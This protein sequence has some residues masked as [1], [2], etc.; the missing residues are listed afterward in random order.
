MSGQFFFASGED[1]A[2]SKFADLPA[3]YRY[4]APPPPSSISSTSTLDSAREAGGFTPL[5]RSFEAG[6]LRH[7]DD[8]DAVTKGDDGEQIEVDEQHPSGPR[9]WGCFLVTIPVFMGY[10]TLIKLQSNLRLHLWVAN[11]SDEE[12]GTRFLPHSSHEAYLFGLCVSF[13][14]F[15]L[16][17]FRI[18]HNLIFGF[19][20]TM[21]KDEHQSLLSAET[22]VDVV[23]AAVPSHPHPPTKKSSSSIKKTQKRT[24][25]RTASGSGEISGWWESESSIIHPGGINDEMRSGGSPQRSTLTATAGDDDCEDQE[26]ASHISNSLLSRFLNRLYL[27]PPG[28]VVFACLLMALSNLLVALLFYYV[29]PEASITSTAEEVRA[30]IGIASSLTLVL[31]FIGGAAVAIFEPNVMASITPLGKKNKSLAAVGIPFGT[32]SVTLVVLV[33]LGFGAPGQFIHPALPPSNTTNVTTTSSAPQETFIQDW[34][35]PSPLDAVSPKVF[36]EEYRTYSQ[37]VEV[38]GYCVAGSLCVAAAIVFWYC[39]P[40]SESLQRHDDVAQFIHKIRNVRDKGWLYQM[41]FPLAVSFFDQICLAMSVAIAQY[42]YGNKNGVPMLY[43]FVSR[44]SSDVDNHRYAISHNYFLTAYF[45]SAFFGAV[46]ARHFAFFTK[47]RVNPVWYLVGIVFPGIA[48]VLSTVP[49]VALVGIFLIMYGNGAVYA[50][51]IR[52]IDETVAADCNLV[53]LSIWMAMGDIGGFVGANCVVPVHTLL[54]TI[55]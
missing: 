47:R 20:G 6:V 19:R 2:D 13:Y 3:T 21:T 8:D 18:G 39:V 54:G 36:N 34:D 42:L 4:R 44:D 38:G 50:S 28:R 46:F 17:V 14:Y 37:W 24:D 25:N 7:N 1:Y 40:R 35:A 9:F 49:I 55:G 33:A 26:R 12:S 11:S 23:S 16:F 5:T 15:G 41:R 31:Y 52:I 45:V 53:A 27:A 22:G 51:S 29:L 30:N 48:M 43:P 10:G 32:N